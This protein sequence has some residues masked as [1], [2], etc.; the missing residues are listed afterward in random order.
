MYH[1][2][3]L[4]LFRERFGDFDC[5][6]TGHYARV[7]YDTISGRFLLRKSADEKKDQSY[8]LYNLDQQQLKKA[9][10]PLGGLLKQQVRKINEEKKLVNILKS[11]S[12]D[13]CF[14]PDGDYGNFIETYTKLFKEINS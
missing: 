7:E 6:V 8:V 5:Y 14:V 10:F 12:Q 11:E 2:H 9:K 4:Q 3:N 1:G 13:I